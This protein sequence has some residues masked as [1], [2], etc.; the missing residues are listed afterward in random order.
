MARAI[1]ETPDQVDCD[2]V[3]RALFD[4]SLVLSD[5]PW[6]FGAGQL[7]AGRAAGLS[8]AALLHAVVQSAYFNYLN[9]VADAT[10][11]DFDYESPLPRI[12]IDR[13]RDPHP[14]P[15]PAAWPRPPAVFALADRPQTAERFTAWRQLLF[16][17][18]QPLTRRDRRLVARAAALATCDAAGA[19]ALATG[20]PTTP[21]E[22]ALVAYADLLSRAPW[23]L[24]A[25]DLA[26]LRAAGL[27]DRALLDLITVASFQNTASRLT[28][29]GV[30]LG[31]G[32]AGSIA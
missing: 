28:L 26:P 12:P 27:D 21:R 23:R 10:G 22:H 32:E 14:R 11:I 6:R 24:G 25:A 15:P 17:R 30:A 2:P 29:A 31:E 3:S 9:R 4:L 16:D 8:D 20:E 7:D 18:D 1:V 19:H 5:E 13:A